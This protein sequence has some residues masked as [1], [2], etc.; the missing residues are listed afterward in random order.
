MLGWG[1]VGGGRM[2]IKKKWK[3][4]VKLKPVSSPQLL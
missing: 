2:M 4:L 1:R 3:G